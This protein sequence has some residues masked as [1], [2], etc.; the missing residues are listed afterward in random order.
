MVSQTNDSSLIA[1][2]TD[3]LKQA[4]RAKE[5]FWKQRSS[6]LWLSLGDRNSGYFHA[7]TK[8]RTALNSFSIIEDINRVPKFGEKETVDVVVSYYQELFTAGEGNQNQTVEEAIFPKITN[9]MNLK[10]IEEPT[11][12][13]IKLAVFSIH[14]D[15]APRPDG[16][17]ASFF[18]SN[19]STVG[20]EIIAEIQEF[21]SVG[22]LPR[23]VT[24][25][26]YVSFPKFRIQRK[27]RTTDR[28]L[29]VILQN[30]LKSV[31]PSTTADPLN[32]HLRKSIRI[33]LGMCNLGQCPDNTRDVTLS[34]DFG[35]CE[36]LL[37]GSKDRHEQNIRQIGMEVHQG[38]TNQIW[39][40]YQVGE[41]GDAMCEHGVVLILY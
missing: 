30:N 33:R 12:E 25:P 41:L 26:L 27:W 28:S 16:F 24:Q 23:Q 19:W 9:Q 14:A 31:D 18:H 32:S 22:V 36:I 29:S 4:Y 2:L 35:S 21:F 5:E 8:S 37:H 10:L 34:Q 17:S 20:E 1:S 6:N 11:V 38:S 39:V 13:E 15:K 3:K 40:P 7:V